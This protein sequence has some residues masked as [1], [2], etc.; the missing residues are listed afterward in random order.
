[1]FFAKAKGV[2]KQNTKVVELEALANACKVLRGAYTCE[3]LNAD[4]SSVASNR[5]KQS[6]ATSQKVCEDSTRR[7]RKAKKSPRSGTGVQPNSL[8]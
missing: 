5:A 4:A 6:R 7:V 3:R 1:M 2:K 8:Y